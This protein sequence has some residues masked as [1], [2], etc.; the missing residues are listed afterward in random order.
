MGRVHVKYFA[1]LREAAGRDEEFVDLEKA[2]TGGALYLR[3]KN[4]YGFSLHGNM[5]RVAVNE[6]FVPAET[7][8]RD[9]DE[10]VFIPPVAG[11]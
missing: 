8:L 10:V 1:S 11:G 3:L 7:V 5:V 4:Q 6:T 2:E 9:A